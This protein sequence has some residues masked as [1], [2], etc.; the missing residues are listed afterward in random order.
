MTEPTT[1]PFESKR[2]AKVTALQHLQ[3]AIPAYGLAMSGVQALQRGVEGLELALA[4]AGLVTSTALVVAIVRHLRHVGEPPHHHGI[5]WVTLL[6]AAMLFTEAGERWH[7]THHWFTPE[8]LTALAT[9]FAAIGTSW[10]TA[11]RR[12]RRMLQ[13]SD[14]GVEIRRG[15]LRR[16]FRAAW[17]EIVSIDIGERE[18]V[19]RTA[20]GRSGR[21]DLADLHN[22]SQV[23]SALGDARAH[24][25]PPPSQ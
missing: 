2:R 9:V 14:T 8:M 21:I 10:I 1:I 4:I 15:P 24:I 18:A 3:H 11:R 13:L 16:R 25:P 12:R 19:I 17:N 6:A 5:D 23:V 20:R 22:A 7:R